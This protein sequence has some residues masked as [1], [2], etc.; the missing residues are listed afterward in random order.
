MHPMSKT[1]LQALL[2]QTLGTL[3]PAQL[4]RVL[5]SLNRHYIADRDSR[6]LVDIVAEL[7]VG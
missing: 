2:G 6:A 1:Q 4:E 7:G 3:T 5:D